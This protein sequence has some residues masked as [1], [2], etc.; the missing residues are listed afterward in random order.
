MCCAYKKEIPPDVPQQFP[1]RFDLLMIFNGWFVTLTLTW[2]TRNVDALQC[3]R[4]IDYRHGPLKKQVLFFH[5]TFSCSSL[6]FLFPLFFCLS[7]RLEPIPANESCSSTVVFCYT[8][9]RD[10]FPSWETFFGS[11]PVV[12]N[13]RGFKITIL[14]TCASF[15]CRGSSTTTDGTQNPLGIKIKTFTLGG[16]LLMV[17]GERNGGGGVGGLSS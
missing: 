11:C 10:P 12:K 6:A 13:K 17:N 4:S 15:S 16:L 1:S 14:R 5:I 3:S 8:H 7:K 9:P 2:Q